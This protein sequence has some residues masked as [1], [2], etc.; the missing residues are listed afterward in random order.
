MT[1]AADVEV[2][3]PRMRY[4]IMLPM[5]EGRIEVPGVSLKPGAGPGGTIIGKDSPI[6]SGDFGLVD[7]NMGNLLP[8]I[9]A[10]WE[11]V[12]LPVFSKRKHVYTYI[13]CRADAGIRAPKD[14]EGKRIGTGRYRSAITIWIRGLLQHRYG[15]DISTLRWFVTGADS[16]PIHDPN[17]KIEK[18]AQSNIVDSLFT[19]EV[20]AIMTDIS[21]AALFERL[22]TS[23]EIV[24]LFPDYQAEDQALYNETGIFTPVHVM[25]VSRKL[26]RQHPDLAGKLYAAFE[27][28]KQT[29]YEDILSDMRGFSLLYLREGLRDQ[30][31]AWGDPFKFG[32]TANNAAIDTFFQYN[33]EQ[34]M[35]ASNHSYEDVFA[36]STLDT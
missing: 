21:D 7:L 10:G 11:I 22:E 8:G 25:T 3:F 16:F 1:Q 32:I 4:D 34:G 2:G 28:S 20:D 35:A 17:V 27:R 29:A 24:R 18:A 36:S 23:P 12:A 14:L 9:E 13:F 30:M 19:G 33:V 15:V 31:A 26:D 5:L 6:P